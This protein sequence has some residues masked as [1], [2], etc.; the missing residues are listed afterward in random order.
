M[1]DFVKRYPVPFILGA[2]IAGLLFLAVSFAGPPAKAQTAVN[3]TRI[4]EI[5]KEAKAL[6][7]TIMVVELTEVESRK[8]EDAI[9]AEVGS[10]A[11]WEYD[12]IVYMYNSAVENSVALFY[13][14]KDGQGVGTLKV[15]R[16]RARQ[17]IQ[18][19]LGREV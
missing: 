4:E 13:F 18:T 6:A 14:V 5:I 12:R 16:D 8:V 1:L 15:T 19:A 11:P 7:D 3:D 17:F 9:E 2:A 10:R